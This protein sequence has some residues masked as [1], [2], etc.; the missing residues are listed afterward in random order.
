MAKLSSQQ[1]KNLPRGAFA[2]PRQGRRWITQGK[3]IG[4]PGVHYAVDPLPPRTQ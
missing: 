2:I 4:K 3:R 1:R